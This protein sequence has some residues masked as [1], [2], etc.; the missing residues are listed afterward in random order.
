MKE[1]IDPG[2]WLDRM[3]VAFASGERHRLMYNGSLDRFNE[4]E[5]AQAEQLK[6][7]ERDHSVID[8]GCGYGRLP[9]L[10][11]RQ[12]W[13]GRYVGYDLSPDL[14]EVARRWWP[15][16]SQYVFE[17]ADLTFAPPTPPFR[18]RW[19]VSLWMKT[20]LVGNGFGREWDKIEEW[21][22]GVADEVL[23]ID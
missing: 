15:D 6:V 11:R 22:R 14:I 9:E 10:L 21:M 1:V 13:V 18:A 17:V 19:V 2:Y 8:A 3:Y 12:G 5:A 16:P 20:M 7:I 23:I 4:I